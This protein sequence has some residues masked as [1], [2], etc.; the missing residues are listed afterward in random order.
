[1]KSLIGIIHLEVQGFIIQENWINGKVFLVKRD[2]I[3]N[4]FTSNGNIPCKGLF[5]TINVQEKIVIFRDETFD[6]T[7]NRCCHM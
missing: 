4:G 5:R 6:K 7:S 2:V 3:I 1:M